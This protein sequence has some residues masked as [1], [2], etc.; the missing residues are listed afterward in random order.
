MDQT[1]REFL[2]EI[3]DLVEHIFADLDELRA[4]TTE[5]PVRR[6]LIDR[7]FRR[8]H[9]VKGAVASSGLEVVSHIAHEFENLLDEVR[10]GRV[11]VDE[12]ALNTCESAAEALSESLT[13]A[14]S[15]IVEPSRR[16]LFDRLQA[17]A[18]N[19]VAA[20][21]PTDS[22]AILRNIPFEIWE[23]LTESEKHQLL[24]IVAEGSPLFVVGTSFDVGNFDAE[25][26]R[27]KEQ[28]ARFGEVISTSPRVDDEQPDK[29]NFR[30]LYA[31]NTDLQTVET[32]ISDF[33]PL[34]FQEIVSAGNDAGAVEQ[35]ASTSLAQAS[36]STL[37]NFVRTDLDRLDRLIS[38]THALLRTT[39]T[40]L[41]LAMSQL[42]VPNEELHKLNREI[43]SS[44]IRL[45]DELINL[46]LASLGP[47][48]NRAVRAGRAAARLDAKEINFEVSGA[49]IRLD[50]LL[51]EAIA[52]P[53][54]HLVRN[55]V[56]HGIETVDERTQ[57]GKPPRGTVRVEAISEGSQSR[58]RVVDNGRGVDPHVISAAAQRLGLSTN[59]TQLG[60]EQSLRMI[61]R[62]GFTTLRSASDLSGRGVGLDVVETA[63]EQ[64]GGELRVSSK[65]G[66]G[67]T[68]EIR[69][70]VTFGLIATNVIVSAGKHYC[71]PANQTLGIDAIDIV[72]GASGANRI[73]QVSMRDLL[74]QPEEADN[75][76][77]RLQLITCQFTDERAGLESEKTKSVGIVVDQVET[78]QEVLVRNLGRHAGRW[79]GIA[80]ATELRDGT[81][82]LVLD[83][84]RL[85]S[86][87]LC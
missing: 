85:L 27:L 64:V 69:L 44:F 72:D 78:P 75:S 56:D 86:A 3:E 74:G 20:R 71:I 19:K 9:N 57:A 41:A 83:L 59:D 73:P 26:F 54:I 31:V 22:E 65:P 37:S 40:A 17:A 51:A 34:V 25:F 45:E 46:R 15:G 6:E 33:A 53:L 39:S 77:S 68:F 12:A 10:A 16:T 13:M 70:P 67:T 49:D 29:I 61:F 80:G 32:G 76:T 82:A 30:I 66:Q 14:A 1:Q 36:R 7:V 23:S 43:K 8:V 79:Y 28:L 87:S 55:A 62:P 52:D 58:L 11:L 2:V 18:R 42:P 35:I 60:M 38:S 4:T 63:V 24:S 81:V 50:R 84:P 21:E 48:L 47:T 5:G